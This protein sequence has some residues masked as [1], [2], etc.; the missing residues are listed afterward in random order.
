MSRVFSEKVAVIGLGYVGLPLSI[1]SSNSGWKVIGIDVAKSRVSQIQSGTSPIEDVTNE[2]LQRAL[3]SGFEATTDLTRLSEASIVVI[4]VPT[5]LDENGVPDLESLDQA[6]KAIGKY[7]Q[8]GALVINESTSYPGTARTFIPN[9]IREVNDELN[10]Y[11]ASAPE[12]VDPAN[13]KWSFR[14]TPRLVGATSEEALDRAHN[15]Y[16]TFCDEV[17][18]VRTPEVAE[19]SKLLENAFRQVNIALVNQL[20]PVAD[21]LDVS[22]SE[23]IEAASTKPYGYMPFKPG[24]G[25][26]GHCIPVDPIYLS[27]F[28]A[29]QGLKLELIETAQRINNENPRYIVQRIKSLGRD[30]ESRILL[31]GMSYKPGVRDLRE[32]PSVALFDQLSREFSRVEWWDPLVTHIHL[33]ETPRSLLEGEFDLIIVAH[34]GDSPEILRLTGS[35]KQILDFSGILQ[36]QENVTII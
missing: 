33:I 31:V 11:F 27:W 29:Q 7:G 21:L 19:L 34:S 22:M 20:L 16:S 4:C 25:V 15:F 17:I 35:S 3:K 14:S 23:V 13:K 36:G 18:R 6:C 5:P 12:R 1:V 9:S 30:R 24:I 28:A 8:Q 32:S 2:D 26:G 10:L